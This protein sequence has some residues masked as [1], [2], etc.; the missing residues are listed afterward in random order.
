MLCCLLCRYTVVWDKGQQLWREYYPLAGQEAPCWI[1]VHVFTR[2]TDSTTAGSDSS[3]TSEQGTNS[4]FGP[5]LKDPAPAATATEGSVGTRRRPLQL[6][7]DRGVST[8]TSNSSN[9][10]SGTG[11]GSGALANGMGNSSSSS[12]VSSSPSVWDLPSDFVLY[13]SYTIRFVPLRPPA[14]LS[15]RAI[16]FSNN[17]TTVIACGVPQAWAHLFVQPGQQQQPA[18]ARGAARPSSIMSSNYAAASSRAADSQRTNSSRGNS[19]STPAAAAALVPAP[20]A[21]AAVA[22][23]N[24]SFQ[25]A[26]AG[27]DVGAG[28]AATAGSSAGSSPGPPPALTAAPGVDVQVAY[29]VMKAPGS[30][31][32]SSSAAQEVAAAAKLPDRLR[33]QQFSVLDRVSNRTIIWSRFTSAECAQDRYILLPMAQLKPDMKMVPELVDP[34]GFDAGVRIAMSAAAVALPGAAEANSSTGSSSSSS[35][36]G[37]SGVSSSVSSSS[38][39]HLGVPSDG[40]NSVSSWLLEQKFQGSVF[41][42]N[43]AA[44]AAASAA[45][46]G[47]KGY[48]GAGS[49]NLGD[50][51]WCGSSNSTAAGVMRDTGG[52]GGL[53]SGSGCRLRLPGLTAE[54]PI[55]LTADEGRSSKTYTMLLYSNATAAAAVHDLILPQ[56]AA[57]G[58]SGHGS[59]GSSSQAAD[60]AALS[61]AFFADRPEEWPRSPAQ[62]S[63]CSV[64]PNGTYSTRT[65]APECKVRSC[66]SLLQCV[67]LH[68]GP[69][70]NAHA[71]TF[72]VTQPEGGSCVHSCR[73]VRMVASMGQGCG[74]VSQLLCT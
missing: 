18:A 3:T 50:E 38:S 6:F 64:C 9:G 71:C 11:S 49:R 16:T 60:A 73:V 20:V 55:I 62:N 46:D 45:V 2:L 24:S 70:P 65:D 26:S 74:L 13:R 27:D 17:S 1:R 21:T 69:L 47:G 39:S 56:E 63:Q 12:G 23:G 7:A 52:T 44:A 15:L 72:W 48:G 58:G 22:A 19:T 34:R 28:Q 36:S 57:A 67:V 31:S 59:S 41:S 5:G 32:S 4:E 8:P 51:V 54:L 35:S 33:L 14:Q 37:S 10:S 29:L 42:G 25:P 66:W 43:A 61:L 68:M 30:N 40:S 53:G